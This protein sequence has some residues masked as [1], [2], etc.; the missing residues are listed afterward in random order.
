MWGSSWIAD[1]ATLC[2]LCL[3]AMSEAGDGADI[4]GLSD[5]VSPAKSVEFDG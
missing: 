3:D 5:G 4:C 2:T 1:G